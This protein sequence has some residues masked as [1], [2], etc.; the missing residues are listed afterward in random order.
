MPDC[1]TANEQR[2]KEAGRVVHWGYA[3]S[4]DDVRRGPWWCNACVQSLQ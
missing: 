4:K 2:L 1:F 3:D